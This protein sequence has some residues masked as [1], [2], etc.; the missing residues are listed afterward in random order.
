MDVLPT[1]CL[2][3]SMNNNTFGT[4]YARPEGIGRLASI[5]GLLGSIE[6]AFPGSGFRAW[7][8]SFCSLDAFRVSGLD[9]LPNARGCFFAST[10]FL[11][12]FLRLPFGIPDHIRPVPFVSPGRREG[13]EVEA[14]APS[15]KS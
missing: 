3:N 4:T 10:S 8:D 2:F 11:G 15:K 14:E 6:R 13:R 5:L 12:A 7:R 1:E 9:S